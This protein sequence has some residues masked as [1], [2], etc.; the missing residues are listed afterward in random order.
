[1]RLPS[2]LELPMDRIV[3]LCR[4]YHVKELSVFGSAAR[5]DFRP[6]SDVD[7]LVEFEPEARIS[8]FDFCGLQ[9]EFAKALR[10]EVDLVSKRALK[11]HSRPRILSEA[12]LLYAA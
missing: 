2:G 3:E 5:G 6:E 1:M 9:A 10:R 8:L 12:Q 11:Q 7:F 4:E